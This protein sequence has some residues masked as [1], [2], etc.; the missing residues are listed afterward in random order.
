M[1]RLKDDNLP[2]YLAGMKGNIMVLTVREYAKRYRLSIYQVIKKL[3][4]GE[5]QG[6]HK[7]D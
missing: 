2:L 5:L 6:L 3:Q 4:E 7:R 1:E